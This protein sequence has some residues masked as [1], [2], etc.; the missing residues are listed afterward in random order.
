MFLFE[1]IMYYHRY[2]ECA[3]VE[4][5]FHFQ[6]ASP[7]LFHF[8]QIFRLKD[9]KQ[10]L[11]GLYTYFQVVL[12]LQSGMSDSQPC[13]ISIENLFSR[14][15]KILQYTTLDCYSD[16][17]TG[18]K[19]SFGFVCSQRTQKLSSLCITE[20]AVFFQLAYFLQFVFSS[21]TDISLIFYRKIKVFR[22][23]QCTMYN[24]CG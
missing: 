19:S 16:L 5:F 1:S 22:K 6:F 11:K 18:F 23:L 10:C 9:V 7:V 20:F 17:N 12:L 13:H 24:L 15:R 21:T 2:F 8:I 3:P 14:I 4:E